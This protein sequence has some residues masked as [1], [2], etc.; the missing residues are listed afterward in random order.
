MIQDPPQPAEPRDDAHAD[1][2][3]LHLRVRFDGDVQVLRHVG[4]A[5]GEGDA[6]EH[7]D[8]EGFA[9]RG[10]AE[11]VPRESAEGVGG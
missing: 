5:F 7:A 8:G 6:F 4:G 10:P 9:F 11:D 1:V 2:V 3:E